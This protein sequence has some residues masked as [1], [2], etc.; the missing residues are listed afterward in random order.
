MIHPNLGD[1]SDLTV[2][3]LEQKV[4]RL[5][6]VYF[7]TQD[8]SVRHQIILLIDSYKI[9]LEQRRMQQR[10][11]EQENGNSDLDNLINVS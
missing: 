6:S 1:L 3:E 2:N 10:K 7:M 11:E 4:L 8:E 9:E 5:N